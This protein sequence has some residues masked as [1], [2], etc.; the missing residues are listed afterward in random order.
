MKKL[1]FIFITILI[2]VSCSHNRQ[3]PAPVKSDSATAKAAEKN[4]DSTENPKDTLPIIA[5][6]DIRADYAEVFNDSNCLQLQSA[7]ELGIEPISR[8]AEAYKTRRPIV[9]VES[10]DNYYV[11]YLTHSM[12]YLVPEAAGLLEEIGKDFEA[13]VE[14]N[15]GQ[16]GNKFI[17]TSLLRSPYSVKKLRKVN[18]NAVD[19]S[20]HMFGTTFDIAYNA[21]Y[22]DDS[23]K[24]MGTSRL[25]AILAEV[26]YN[27]RACGKC[28]V[29]YE[30]KS[31]CFHIT[32][33]NP[34]K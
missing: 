27:K 21:F 6:A 15:G 23:V 10:G 17:V 26:L 1:P 22:C 2:A 12:P 13:A 5:F 14:K 4:V 16:R 34:G 33:R 32:V 18:K 7:K 19:S 25:K 24:P 30:K 20:T 9:K 8:I 31:P 3:A 28:H 29:K 11:D